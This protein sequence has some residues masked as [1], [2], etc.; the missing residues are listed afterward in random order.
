MVAVEHRDGSGPSTTIKLESGE[1]KY[2]DFLGWQDVEWPDLA[3]QP[4]DDTT[5]R[6][7][8]LAL[9]LAEIEETLSVI[10]AINSGIPVAETSLRSPDFDW[11]RW[12]DTIDVENPIMAGHSLGP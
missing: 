7:D 12:K 11:S 8:Q 4:S 6:K 2:L 1:T 3:E 10:K 5:L 9:R